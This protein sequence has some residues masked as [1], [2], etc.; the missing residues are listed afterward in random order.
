MSSTTEGAR[1]RRNRTRAAIT[2]AAALVAA[3]AFAGPRSAVSRAG[4]VDVTGYP[5]SMTDAAGAQS[6]LCFGPAPE[7]G[8][9]AAT[10]VGHAHR[11]R[12]V[13]LGR[14][15][16][17]VRAPAARSASSSTS[18]LRRLRRDLGHPARPD[19]VP[20]H[21]DQRRHDP[22][23]R[24]VHVR[25]PVRQLHLA[26]R[27]P[28]ARRPAGTRSS[29]PATPPVGPIDHFLTSSTAPAGFYGNADASA[30]TTTQTTRH[31][32]GLHA[33]RGIRADP[34][35]CPATSDQWVIMGGSW[36]HPV[37]LPA[38]R[39]RQGRHP[40]HDGQ[41]PGRRRPGSNGGCPVATTP[42]GGG[43]GATG[44]TAGTTNTT[45]TIVQV[46]PGPSAGVLGAQAW[47]RW[48]SAG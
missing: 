45:T 34:L 5:A 7:C 35:V 40:G 16:R 19:H 33:R 29:R 37:V 25:D 6:A 46:I 36:A 31:G 39:H 22:A 9:G 47:S 10:A 30:V 4:P 14:L 18:R 41:L 21:P 48:L 28:P 24:H 11:R 32:L 17:C 15:R 27:R 42:A 26:R 23:Q 1:A 20:A 44:S 13:L 8:A 43:G 2:T 12:G 38:R 3:A